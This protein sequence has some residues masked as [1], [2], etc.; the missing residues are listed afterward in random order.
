MHGTGLL[1]RSIDDHPF[2]ED[3]SLRMSSS[4]LPSLAIPV[5]GLSGAISSPRARS[6]F[7]GS[8]TARSRVCRRR[9]REPLCDLLLDGGASGPTVVNV[10]PF[11]RPTCERRASTETRCS[12]NTMLRMPMAGRSCSRSRG[13]RAEADRP[14][15]RPTAERPERHRQAAA[16]KREQTITVPPNVPTTFT[17]FGRRDKTSAGSSPGPRPRSSS[18]FQP[19]KPNGIFRHRD[20]PFVAGTIRRRSRT[21]GKR[22]TP[23]SFPSAS[24]SSIRRRIS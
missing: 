9:R 8:G 4:H 21:F 5:S 17:F 23:A 6:S 14:S 15:I 13:D 2:R 11:L 1:R 24:R 22:G 3:S 7:S 16:S 18:G 19:R 20:E 10:L 12:W